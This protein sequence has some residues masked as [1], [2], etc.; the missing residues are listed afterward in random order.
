MRKIETCSINHK[1][2][3]LQRP[4]RSFSDIACCAEEYLNK[5]EVIE[6]DFYLIGDKQLFGSVVKVHFA[7]S[8]HLKVLNSNCK[9]L[10]EFYFIISC[11]PESLKKPTN[12]KKFKTRGEK[13]L[14]NRRNLTLWKHEP[15]KNCW[16]SF[17]NYVV[18]TRN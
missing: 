9:Y 4:C 13:L 6:T 2:L 14:S 8:V 1:D 16:W 7:W 15:P 11:V 18:T 5:L 12:K 17:N 3:F 10:C